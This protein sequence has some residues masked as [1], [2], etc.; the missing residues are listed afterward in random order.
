MITFVSP[1]AGAPNPSPQSAS[2]ADAAAKR[3]AAIVWPGLVIA[4]L[5]MQVLMCMIA[6]SFA[7]SDPSHAI[8]P[9]YYK[10]SLNWDQSQAQKRAMTALGWSVAIRQQAK[11]PTGERVLRFSPHDKS[12]AAILG[13]TVTAEY[14]HHARANQRDT[15]STTATPDGEYEAAIRMDRVGMWEFRITVRRGT[16]V[17]SE[18]RVIRLSESGNLLE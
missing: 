13:A 15:L 2:S 14:F 16:D 4:L 18:T 1:Q 17:W 3:W 7:T 11:R 5:A 8:E 10:K 6:V 12:G 9:D